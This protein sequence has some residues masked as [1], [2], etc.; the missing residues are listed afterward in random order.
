[1]MPDAQIEAADVVLAT[2][3]F[4]VFNHAEVA[5]GISLPGVAGWTTTVH[6]GSFGLGSDEP[7]GAVMDRWSALQSD[8]ANIGVNR[9]A[10]AHQVHGYAVSLHQDGWTG[11]LR[12]RG[13]DGHVSAVPGTALA[14][15]VA[16]CTPVFVAHPKAVAM[17]H[18][19]WRGT[20]S[21][22]LKAGLEA[23]L[24]LGALPDE[25]FVHL[26]PS[27]CAP[28]YE[29]GPEV[30]TAVT[31][32]PAKGKGHLDVR[33]VLAEQAYALGV[34]QLDVSSWCT[35]CGGGRF[36]SHR[37]GDAGR[38]LGVIVYLGT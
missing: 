28:C 13:V 31:G 27:I 36:F 5:S 23:M 10:S 2:P 16:D 21:H 7:V 29:V 15:T 9:L 6:N 30:L 32:L 38:Q 17:L 11:W 12:Q 34:R 37:G 25:C 8:L 33:A 35:R 4:T 14:V 1:M 18:A 24:T 19:G 3:A 20:A 22:I 26:G